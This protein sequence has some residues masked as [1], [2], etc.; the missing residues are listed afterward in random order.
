MRKTMQA[1]VTNRA[2]LV[3]KPPHWAA[4]THVVKAL[5]TMAPRVK[6]PKG[7]KNGGSLSMTA[8]T[9]ATVQEEHRMRSIASKRQISMIESQ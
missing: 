1:S 8:N 7:A 3:R 5:Q 9:P 2:P 6:R 4:N